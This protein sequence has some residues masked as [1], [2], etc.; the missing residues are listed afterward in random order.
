MRWQVGQPGPHITRYWEPSFEPDAS[1]TLAEAAV[2][3]R[4]RVT[5]AVRIRMV[6]DVPLGAFLSG[7]VD[8]SV[9][10]ATMAR[11][12]AEPVRTC[13]IGFADAAFD[14]SRYA[15]RVAAQYRTDHRSETVDDA[16]SALVGQLA[17][18]FDEPF[19][20][21]S[22]LP[23]WR[24]CRLAR[25]RVTVALSGDGGDEVFGGYRRYLGSHYRARLDRVPGPL[26]RVAIALA[27]H[28]LRHRGQMGQS[29]S[30]PFGTS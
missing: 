12:S 26:R 18:L 24:V 23:T 30:W 8:S 10:V 16:Q 19:A 3:L 20:D 21:S 7:G 27:D 25:Q 14:E 2:E 11:L 5:E 9:V 28:F 29:A 4:E 1:I 13:S 6:A 17:G 22:A 15:A